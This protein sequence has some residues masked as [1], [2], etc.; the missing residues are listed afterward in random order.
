MPCPS[1]PVGGALA[2][3]DT[4]RSLRVLFLNRNLLERVENV[5]ALVNL[6]VLN[7]SNNRLRSVAGV[8]AL[9]RLATLLVSENLLADVG[10]LQELAELEL[11]SE[12]DLS[13]N[14]IADTAA[15]DV[16]ERLP[17]LS[18]LQLEKN[19]LSNSSDLRRPADVKPI[20]PHY[21]KVV[22]ARLSNLQ[23][24]DHMPVMPQ[25]RRYVDRWYRDEAPSSRPTSAGDG[26]ASGDA[27]PA[28]AL[29]ALVSRLEGPRQLVQFALVSTSWRRA[30]DPRLQQLRREKLDKARSV[31]GMRL[32]ETQAELDCLTQADLAEVRSFRIAPTQV[33]HCL[34]ALC[35]LVQ[36]SPDVAAAIPDFESSTWRNRA[37]ER[38]TRMIGDPGFLNEM[39]RRADELVAG[40]D[41]GS[42]AYLRAATGSAD[43]LD[44]YVPPLDV[45][46]VTRACAPFGRLASWLLAVEDAAYV[47]RGFVA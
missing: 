13:H 31:S 22:L 8:G 30:A 45:R 5:S 27:L 29:H 17:K 41:G 1:L 14:Q 15:I 18:V 47:A 26:A 44:E 46:A 28:S 38:A 16:L 35:V 43:D 37:W 19:P 24:L 23:S 10:G 2:P 39:R 11:L 20:L 6:Q 9:P 4:L 25:E 33:L 36:G 32:A 7:L 3:Q 21:R 42:L 12:L 40:P 34:H